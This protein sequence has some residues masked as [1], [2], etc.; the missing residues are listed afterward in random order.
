ME[1]NIPDAEAGEIEA[2]DDEENPMPDEGG[3]H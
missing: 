2:D 1:D 3:K